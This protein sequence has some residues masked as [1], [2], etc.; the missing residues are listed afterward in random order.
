MVKMI[1][2][3]RRRPDLTR[4]PSGSIGVT[5]TRP[6]SRST[7]PRQ[8]SSD[9]SKSMRSKRLRPLAGLR[10]STESGEVWIESIEA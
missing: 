9:T 10:A 6:S 3:L 1:I 4:N 5:S 8:A 7:Q 2:C